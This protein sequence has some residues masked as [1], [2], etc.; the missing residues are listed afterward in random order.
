MKLW[1]EDLVLFTVMKISSARK[2]GWGVLASALVVTSIAMAD[3]PSVSRGGVP[4]DTIRPIAKGGVPDDGVKPM[5]QLIP[6]PARGA[7]PAPLEATK[8]MTKMKEALKIAGVPAAVPPQL[9]LDTRISPAN[10]RQASG[11]IT[12]A[13]TAIW[14]IGAAN[15]PDGS[16]SLVRPN[17]AIAMSGVDLKLTT[18]VGKMYL[19]DCRLSTVNSSIKLIIVRNG[20]AMPLTIEDGHAVHAFQAKAAKTDVSIKWMPSGGNESYFGAF[21]GCEVGKA[22]MN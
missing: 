3:P 6:L 21:Y 1:G 8:K 16:I 17:G 14:S 22:N 19:M 10:P 12:Y 5:S 13:G 20:S 2:Y 18:E 11:E 9:A 7:A 4:D 15:E